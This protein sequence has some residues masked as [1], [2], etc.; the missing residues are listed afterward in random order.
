[1][2]MKQPGTMRSVNFALTAMG[3]VAVAG[4]LVALLVIT[5][6]AAGSAAEANRLY[7]VRM[8]WLS[9]ALL[10]LCLLMFAWVVVRYCRQRISGPHQPTKT[11]YF[12]AWGEA[13]RRFKLPDDEQA[14]TDTRSPQQ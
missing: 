2:E 6:R 4:V 7:F 10:A 11:E 1:M 3:L 9:A 5:A 14:D 13:G 12:D 8:A